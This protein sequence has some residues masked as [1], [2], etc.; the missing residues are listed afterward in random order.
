M[1]ELQERDSTDLDAYI[2][3]SYWAVS[4]MTTVGYGDISAHS[5]GER[6]VSMICMAAG[7][8]VFTYLMG[9]MSSIVTT[10]SA[11]DLQ[12]QQKRM[13]RSSLCMWNDS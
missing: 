8:T 4:T 6:L 5:T 2:T 9:A 13:V 1:Q 10:L 12:L 3:A 7:I 11:A